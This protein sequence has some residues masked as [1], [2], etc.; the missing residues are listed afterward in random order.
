MSV[1]SLST[2]TSCRL[3]GDIFVDQIDLDVGLIAF[4]GLRFPQSYARASTVLVDELDAGRFQCT[5]NG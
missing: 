3:V 1:H 4:R 5:A 2:V